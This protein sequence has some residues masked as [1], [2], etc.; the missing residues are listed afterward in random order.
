MARKTHKSSKNNCLVHIG[1][2]IVCQTTLLYESQW[3]S[4]I[5]TPYWSTSTS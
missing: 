2:N 1:F 5:P 4:L 3:T